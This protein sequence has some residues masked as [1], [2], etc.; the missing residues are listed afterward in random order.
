MSIKYLYWYNNEM[1]NASPRYALL[2]F[3]TGMYFMSAIAQHGKNFAQYD[4][5]PDYSSLQTDFKFER[6]NNWSGFINKSFYF[7]HLSPDHT[8]EKI[9]D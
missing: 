1:K 6:I 9:S 3:D 7:V 2:G 8:I 4:L 5:F